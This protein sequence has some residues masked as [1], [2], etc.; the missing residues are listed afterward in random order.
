MAI[1]ER[2]AQVVNEIE[3]A[4]NDLRERRRLLTALFWR[5]LRPANPAV[6]ETRIRATDQRTRD[7]ESRLIMLRNQQEELIVWAL[8]RGM[9]LKEIKSYSLFR[10]LV[11]PI[12]GLLTYR[13]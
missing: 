7:P 9:R 3:H 4:E 10:L 8:T 12:S 2:L 13:K 5:H 6:V 11:F 1:A